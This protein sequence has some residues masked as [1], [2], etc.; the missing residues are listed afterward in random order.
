MLTILKPVMAV[1]CNFWMSAT[2]SLV[3]LITTFSLPAQR[4]FFSFQHGSPGQTLIL[5]CQREKEGRRA[6][7]PGYLLTL[8]DAFNSASCTPVSLHKPEEIR[9]PTDLFKGMFSRSKDLKKKSIS[10]YKVFHFIWMIFGSFRSCHSTWTPF[11]QILSLNAGFESRGGML[12]ALIPWWDEDEQTFG[13]DWDSGRRW[14]YDIMRQEGDGASPRLCQWSDPYTSSVSATPPPA[15][16][17][18]G[19]QHRLSVQTGMFRICW[20]CLVDKTTRQLGID[21]L[22]IRMFS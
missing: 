22:G 6:G 14:R 16:C 12:Q 11:A 2:V 3:C 13:M 1:Y 20:G 10:I 5:L 19:G 21:L 9:L 15:A 7:S 17:K 4:S 18:H 8:R